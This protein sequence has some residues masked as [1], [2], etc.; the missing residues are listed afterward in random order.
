MAG[1]SA[2]FGLTFAATAVIRLDGAAASMPNLANIDTSSIFV[3]GGSTLGTVGGAVAV[4]MLQ[5]QDRADPAADLCRT[6]PGSG[7]YQSACTTVP[8]WRVATVARAAA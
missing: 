3:S 5:G 2:Y 7:G 8:L 6:T 1:A 4:A